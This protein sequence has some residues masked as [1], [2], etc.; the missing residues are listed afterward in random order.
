VLEDIKEA[1]TNLIHGSKEEGKK[2][3]WRWALFTTLGSFFLYL[4]G[5]LSLRFHLSTFGVATDLAVLDERYLFAGAQFLVYFLCSI[6]IVL[7]F[8]LPFYWLLRRLFDAAVERWLQTPNR[9]LI[10]GVVI[11]VLLIQFVVRQCLLFADN[12]LLREHLPQPEWFGYLLLAEGGGLQSLYFSGLVACVF[13]LVAVLWIANHQPARPSPIWNGL[14]GLLLVIQFLLLPVTFGILIADED[15]PR[16]TSLNGKELL[17]PNEEAWR[18]WEGSDGV[19]FFV[20]TWEKDSSKKRL[21][22]MGKKNI[23]RTE[24]SRYDRVLKLLY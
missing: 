24:I 13:A 12:L 21:V 5:Y 3:D 22:T 16:V 4:F 9:M 6:P 8:A 15:V 17:K 10:T 11:S 19:T 1:A 14:L 7:L 20:R 23:E 2:P 18:I